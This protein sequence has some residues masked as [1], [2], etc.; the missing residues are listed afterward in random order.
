MAA[1]SNL[2]THLSD[3]VL[4]SDVISEMRANLTDFPDAFVGEVGLDRIFRVPLDYFA[5]RRVLTPFTIS[6]DHQ[7]AILEAQI[8]LAV[9]LGRSISIHSVK[10][11]LNTVQVLDKMAKK[12]GDRWRTISFDMHR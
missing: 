10:S 7:T 12:H 9:E 8:D 1:F 11:Q 6:I 3:P 2:L 5:E 4:L